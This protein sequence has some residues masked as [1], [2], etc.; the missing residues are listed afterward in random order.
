MFSRLF[1]T[2]KGRAISAV[3]FFAICLIAGG[4]LGFLQNYEGA[5]AFEARSLVWVIA[6]I[7]A[8]IAIV[9][10][11][12]GAYWMKS[13]DEAA[14]EAHKWSWYWGGSAGLAVG[15]MICL[16]SMAPQSAQ[17]AIPAMNGRTDP[18]AYAITGAFGLMV[19]MLIGY[20]IAWAW[21]W[22]SRR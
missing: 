13:I 9:G 3:G 15:M 4:V 17:W 1:S 10:F 19:I 18:F 12:Y 2:N 6:V 5:A 14:Q 7:A 16:L 11:A 21:W 22:F 20:G 8:V